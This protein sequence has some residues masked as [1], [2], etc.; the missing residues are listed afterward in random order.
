MGGMWLI[1]EGAK[2]PADARVKSGK[3]I[4]SVKDGDNHEQ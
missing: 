1:P 4:K 2:K 3:Y